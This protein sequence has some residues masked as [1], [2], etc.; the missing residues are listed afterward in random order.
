MT[1]MMKYGF[2][3]AG[4]QAC[5]NS[6]IRDSFSR[7]QVF[8]TTGATAFNRTQKIERQTQKHRDATFMVERLKA[9]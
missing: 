2:E 9:I 5:N 1:E 6:I 4:F 7:S 3:D 8:S